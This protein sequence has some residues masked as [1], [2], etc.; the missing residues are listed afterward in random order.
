MASAVGPDTLI[1]IKVTYDGVNRRFK[2][3][4]RDLGAYTFPLKIRE[5]LSIPQ[6][7]DIKIQRYSDSLGSNVLLESENKAVYKQLYRAAKA[8]L[9]LRILV[10][11]ESP[12]MGEA[13]MEDNPSVSRVTPP[14][15]S[16]LDTVLSD[17]L[18]A[19]SHTTPATISEHMDW[20][21]PQEYSTVA[22]EDS[23]PAPEPQPTPEWTF[24]ADAPP[25]RRETELPLVFYIDCNNCGNTIPNAHYHCS[26]CEAGDYDLCQ[27][28]ID[29]GTLCPGE[30]HWL[31]KR[32]VENGVVINSTTETIEPKPRVQ[33]HVEP[34]PE[35][36]PEHEPE[37]EVEADTESET[38]ADRE[39]TCNV[40]FLDFAESKLV[41]CLDCDD[42]DLCFSCIL[43]NNHGH[44]P[45]HT[46]VPI[47]EDID[48][49]AVADVVR[50]FCKPGRHQG[51][52]ALCDGCDQRIVGVRYKCLACPDWDYCSECHD[53]A[54]LLHP[55]HRFVPIYDPLPG[56]SGHHRRHYGIYCDGPLCAN[57][58]Q[59]YVTGIRYKCAICNDTD[60]C[61]NCEAHPS[62][63]HNRTHPLLKFKTPVRH[64]SINTIG[65]DEKGEFT[66]G[67]LPQT[68]SAAT[69]PMTQTTSHAS[70]Q[71]SKTV[72]EPVASPSSTMKE[73][74]EAPNAD[75]TSSDELQA[76]F[77][78][79]TIADGS[80]MGTDTVFTQ[81]WTLHNPGPNAWPK[82]CSVRFAGGDS[83]FNINTYAPSSTEEL[84]SAM[85]SH[86]I[87]EPVA[88]LSYADF[89]VTLK[90]SPRPGRAISYW[91]LKTP[92]G[93]P[94]GHRLW[95]DVD[96]Q[97]EPLADLEKSSDS[98]PG[99]YQPEDDNE[100]PLSE[101][102]MVFPKLDKESP[103]ASTHEAAAPTLLVNGKGQDE[104]HDLADDVES[105]TMDDADS[106]GFLTDEEYDILDASDQEF[107]EAQKSAEK[108]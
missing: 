67:D 23:A 47:R 89:T 100:K 46:F 82:G 35:P 1:A 21:K 107:A 14:R 81:T 75:V 96:V 52:A 17:P 22:E 19:E 106:D 5:I 8:K 74:K 92:D 80:K 71:V 24:A 70:T 18:P 104:A 31:I 65:E 34:E 66:M 44:H 2:L 41:T 28:C 30:D 40:C 94:F 101:S 69:E 15:G 95:C 108:K 84:M 87:P 90:S 102:N 12:A 39:R 29:A 26:I 20:P 86:D 50:P 16:Y 54:A 42:Y 79:D 32:F 56:A 91:R 51:H 63:K 25:K 93:V 60:F 76:F 55:R 9:K 37:P 48:D 38:W 98:L 72:D 49:D 45:G 103:E 27:D 61:A 36:E 59:S 10:S 78:R 83:M 88:P 7:T 105:L 85:E 58:P 64:V 77:V 6:D 4:L 97:Q 43:S 53:N 33:P 13:E 73:E 99:L 3:P 62:N 68:K 57:K 11:T